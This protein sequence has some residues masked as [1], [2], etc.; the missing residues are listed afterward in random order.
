VGVGEGVDGFVA[1]VSAVVLGVL[2][3][4]EGLGRVKVV[5]VGE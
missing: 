1:D 5:L 2:E 4:A 3:F